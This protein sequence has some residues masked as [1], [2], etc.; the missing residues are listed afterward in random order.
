MLVRLGFAG[1]RDR[2]QVTLHD[3]LNHRLL[4]EWILQYMVRHFVT[5]KQVQA[6]KRHPI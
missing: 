3:Q 5:H 2:L 1:T 4:L 6:D